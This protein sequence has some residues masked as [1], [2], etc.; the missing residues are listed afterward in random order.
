MMQREPNFRQPDTI[1]IEVV[2]KSQVDPEAWNKAR[3]CLVDC[4]IELL[5]QKHRDRVTI[6]ERHES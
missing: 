5:K 1:Q 3:D 6:G 2:G 4:L